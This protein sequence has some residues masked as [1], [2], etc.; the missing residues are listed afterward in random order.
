VV[1]RNSVRKSNVKIKVKLKKSV[2]G[3]PYKISIRSPHPRTSTAS[4]P[5]SN[6]R[7]NKIENHHGKNKILYKRRAFKRIRVNILYTV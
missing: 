5:K 1:T 6:T 3:V 4:K 7:A 2:S